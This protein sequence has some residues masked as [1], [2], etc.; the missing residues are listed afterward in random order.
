LPA[1][2]GAI[3]YIFGCMFAG[4]TTELFRRLAA[5]EAEAVL[6]FKH[7]RDDR[8]SPT[9]VVAHN[10]QRRP[11]HPIQ[12]VAEIAQHLTPAIRAV[13][14][15]EAHFFSPALPDEVGELADGGL[16]VLLTSLDHDS[17]YREIPMAVALK[18]VA[19]ELVEM[20]TECARCGGRGDHTQRLTPIIDGNLIGGPEAFEPRCATCWHAPPEPPLDR[21]W[22]EHPGYEQKEA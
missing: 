8:Y 9:H 13:A 18:Q 5:Y 17:W 22:R 16:H 11:A 3:T 10:G 14:I 4:K 19:T 12:G 7:A 21:P 1:R 20:T 2:T 15:E 6:C